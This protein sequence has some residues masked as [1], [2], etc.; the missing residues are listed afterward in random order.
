MDM[1]SLLFDILILVGLLNF[2]RQFMFVILIILVKYA[3]R[4]KCTYTIHVYAQS[5]DN[6]F[7]S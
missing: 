3:L 5:V 7:Y 1:A 2:D 6:R 4:T